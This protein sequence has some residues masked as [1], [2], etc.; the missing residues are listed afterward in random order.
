MEVMARWQYALVAVAACADPVIE[1]RLELPENHEQWDTGCT[2]TIEVYTQ[3]ANYPAISNDY[4]G[5][6]FDSSDSPPATYSAVKTM[7]RGQFEV[8]IPESGL[9]GIE[10]YGWDG[11]SGFFSNGTF[12]D[13]AFYSYVPYTGQDV[14]TVE[15]VP[16]LDCRLRPVTVRPIDLITLVTTKNCT[17]AATV[18]PNAFSSMG[19]LS[20]GLFKDYM[21]GW[22]GQHGATVVG[23]VSTF[24]A[25]NMAGPEACVALYASSGTAS[26]GGCV[27]GERAC[28]G[29]NELE[30][31]MVDAVYAMN[32]IDLTIEPQFRG[33]IVGA[34]L[35]AQKNP[36]A[37]ATVAIDETLGKVV[38]VNLD[39]AGK[40]LVATGGRATTASGMF[41]LYTSTLLDT[42]ITAAGRTKTIQL[43]AQR[44]ADDGS[45]LPAGI[46]VTF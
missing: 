10:M 26:T 6:T 13:L 43:G 33:M 40:R 15:L 24:Q 32:S 42:A 41:I 9:G 11:L 38:F 14:I 23:G 39:T 18:D 7:V 1:M 19:T 36:I 31:A 16:N 21:F 35:D 37:G 30:A 25:P 44:T 27:T 5:Q 29:A 12:P 46:V 17:M 45:R 4:I 34:V 2:K 8:A 28:A 3:G 20:P 22:G